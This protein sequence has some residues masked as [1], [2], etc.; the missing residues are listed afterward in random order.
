[1]WHTYFINLIYFYWLRGLTC[2]ACSKVNFFFFRL[3]L[4][5]LLLPLLCIILFWLVHR[6][7]LCHS[8]LNWCITKR[9]SI[10]ILSH[11]DICNEHKKPKSNTYLKVYYCIIPISKCCKKSIF[12]FC[13]I[14]PLFLCQTFII[15]I[16]YLFWNGIFPNKKLQC[17]YENMCMIENVCIV[18]AKTA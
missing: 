3:L 11:N 1:M 13:M 7:L 14:F 16:K 9:K 17:Y 2:L 6:Y 15:V 18:Y 12:L 10:S 5:L 4:R 8:L